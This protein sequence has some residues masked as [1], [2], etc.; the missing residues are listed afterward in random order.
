MFVKGFECNKLMCD[1][2]EPILRY[3]SNSA[4]ALLD[5]Q[6][7]LSNQGTEWLVSFLIFPGSQQRRI[8]LFTK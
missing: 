1:S 7:P 5:S 4:K 3:L 2:F 6:K 8:I